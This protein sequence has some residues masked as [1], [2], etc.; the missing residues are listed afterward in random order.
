[1]TRCPEEYL[2]SVL[3]PSEMRNENLSLVGEMSSS[4]MSSWF[5]KKHDPRKVSFCI[6]KL[7]NV[8]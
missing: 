5:S 8:V 3:Q 7:Q 1:M 4:V 2:V 6:I